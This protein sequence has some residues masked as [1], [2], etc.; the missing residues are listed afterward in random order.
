VES[1]LAALRGGGPV[2]GIMSTLG[3]LGE[4]LAQAPGTNIE[5]LSYRD[6]TT[7]L[8][9]LAPSVDALDKIQHVAAERGITAEIQSANPRDAKIEGRLQFKKAGA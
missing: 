3:T 9:V 2:G 1:R 8:R 4:A 7:D 5:A 6:N